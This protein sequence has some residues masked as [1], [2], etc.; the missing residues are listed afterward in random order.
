MCVADA[1]SKVLKLH[2]F[3]FENHK[4]FADAKSKVLK[5][6]FF[7]FENHKNS[8]PFFLRFASLW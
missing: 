7:V 5:L 3:V 1:K 8:G 6:H 2:F 4:V